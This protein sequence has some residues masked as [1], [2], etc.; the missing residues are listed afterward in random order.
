M[1]DG[2]IRVR[3][4]IGVLAAAGVVGAVAVA[5]NTESSRSVSWLTPGDGNSISGQLDER[6]QNCTVSATPGSAIDHVSFYRDGVLLN[7]EHD[8]PYS[9]IWDT[10]TAAEDSPHTLKAVAY[11]ESGNSVSASVDVI[12]RNG[13]GGDDGEIPHTGV[14]VKQ[15]LAPDSNFMRLWHQLNP[16]KPSQVEWHMGD[17]GDPHPLIEG[18]TNSSWRRLIIR[19]GD[20]GSG[21]LPREE[22]FQLGANSASDSNTFKAYREGER[23]IT[24]WSMRIPSVNIPAGEGAQVWQMYQQG[25][26]GPP[27]LAFSHRSRDTL[28]LIV[29]PGPDKVTLWNVRV[30]VDTWLRFA[31]DI[32]Y[33][34]NAEDAKIQL[35]GDL[36][37][38]GDLS[39]RKLTPVISGYP[40]L[41]TGANAL[42]AGIYGDASIP[43]QHIDFANWQI[44]KWTP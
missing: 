14:V 30:P 15:D 2:G 40:T 12:V 7:T 39:L 31:I 23:W 22:R 36:G 33:T 3:V 24:Y 8:P 28:R 35:W 9:C 4:L 27:I 20:R 34:R 16:Y 41:A 6:A 13:G 44:A 42:I 17:G 32:Q 43:E 25:G 19:D 21:D 38:T 10:T 37:D 11:D 29:R 26:G 18:S 1:E 5:T